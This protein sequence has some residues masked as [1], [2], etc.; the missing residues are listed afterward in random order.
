MAKQVNKLQDFKLHPAKGYSSLSNIRTQQVLL[1]SPSW[2]IPHHPWVTPASFHSQ[3]VCWYLL[4]T[5][6][7]RKGYV[8][9][10]CLVQ[11]ELS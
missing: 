5:F 6:L 11:Q 9:V 10:E 7:G 1:V 2:G 4:F 3:T 8:R